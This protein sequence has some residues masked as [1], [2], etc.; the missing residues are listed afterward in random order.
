[1]STNV[2]PS[3]EAVAAANQEVE[4]IKGGEAATE[5]A[6]TT[7]AA[8]AAAAAVAAVD[9]AEV[10]SRMENEADLSASNA[11]PPTFDTQ[12]TSSDAQPSATET[13]PHASDGQ[14]TL[15]DAQPPPSNIEL[16]MSNAQ[17]SATSTTS[18]KATEEELGDPI[19]EVAPMDVLSGRGASVN[20]HPGN[21][22][23][24]ALCFVR[25]PLFDAGNH[26]AKRRIAT[27][28]V[29]LMMKPQDPNVEPSRFLKRKDDKSPHYAMTEEQAIAKAQQ[30]M[31][32]YKRP[33]RVAI[34]ENLEA[35][36]QLRKRNRTTV[37]TPID[38]VKCDIKLQSSLN[39]QKIL[40]LK[41][42]H[43]VYFS[44]LST[45]HY[46]GASRANY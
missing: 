44:F 15:S 35:S 25:K 22:K 8:A 7:A 26:A 10:F 31:R 38:E 12:P 9:A 24:R 42:P 40:S 27:E 11:P 6:T 21:K 30:V 33:D 18:V 36:G 28:I 37:S 45:A 23:F 5:N 3:F 20:N 19:D 34:R 16:P 32:D 4:Q 29:H 43:H 13:N 46:R 2:D 1:M 41:P 17:P 14:P 39:V